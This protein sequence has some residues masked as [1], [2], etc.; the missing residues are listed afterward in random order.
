MSHSTCDVANDE[1][2]SGGLQRT[3]K[4]PLVQKGEHSW[5]PLVGAQHKM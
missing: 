5:L 1:A 4:W 2:A 3:G